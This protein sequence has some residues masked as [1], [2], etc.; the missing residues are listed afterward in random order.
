MVAQDQRIMVRINQPDTNG[1]P[2]QIWCYAA[3][4]DWTAYSALQSQLTEHIVATAPAFALSI[5]TPGNLT[6]IIKKSNDD[7]P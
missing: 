3:N 1:V 2:L 4:N 7:V 5:Y 6:A